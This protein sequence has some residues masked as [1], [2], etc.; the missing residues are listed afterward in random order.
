MS[1][2][3]DLTSWQMTITCPHCQKKSQ[4]NTKKVKQNTTLMCPH[5]KQFFLPSE[6]KKR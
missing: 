3:T 5:C 6:A 1:Y 2:I 4:Q